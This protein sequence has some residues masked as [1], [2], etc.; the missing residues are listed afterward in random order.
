M[1][2]LLPTTLDFVI[3]DSTPRTVTASNGGNADLTI[4]SIDLTPSSIP[5]F[6]VDTKGCTTP[7][8]QTTSPC[9]VNIRL[10]T[11]SPPPNQVYGLTFKSNA[12]PDQTV[13]FQVHPPP[14]PTPV[15]TP[16]G[17]ILL[18]PGSAPPTV[19]VNFSGSG[20]DP[21]AILA[22][23]FDSTHL[24]DL[25]TDASGNFAVQLAVPDTAPP[26]THQVC[27]GETNGNVCSAFTVEAAP[28]GTPTPSPSASP[29]PSPSASPSGSAALATPDTGGSSP[30]S[31][32][33]KPPFV[34]L[35]I[36]AAIGLLAF[37]GLY[38][39][40]ARPTPPIGEVTILHKAPAP[41]VYDQDA[42]PPPAPP[43]APPKAPIVYESPTA[44]PSTPPP[45]RPPAPPSGADIPPDLPEASD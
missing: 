27:V 13:P 15:P 2:V 10:G 32:L 23:L 17:S 25:N 3:G 16:R 4:K 43:P 19:R 44:P 38:L 18:N 41:R 21:N 39:W 35:P 20:L 14:T 33:T 26:G 40:R 30:L 42:P 5:Y 11:G 31:L 37:L 45:A 8:T 28:A 12:P 1:L 34:F 24:V 29:S 9:Q 22:V 36:I 6:S 7:I